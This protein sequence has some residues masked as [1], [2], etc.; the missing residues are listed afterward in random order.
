MKGVL[1]SVIATCSHDNQMTLNSQGST[2]SDCSSQEYLDQQGQDVPTIALPVELRHTAVQTE[3]KAMKSV[4]VNT[5]R[6]AAPPLSRV[7]HLN[8]LHKTK[9]MTCLVP[10]K[11]AVEK[12]I[13]DDVR[14]RYPSASELS[15]ESPNVLELGRSQSI[16]QFLVRKSE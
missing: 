7:R 15:P 16:G 3:S 14:T 8:G 1:P 9:S 2:E 5:P 12:P 10:P 11:L 13:K 6:P 4:G